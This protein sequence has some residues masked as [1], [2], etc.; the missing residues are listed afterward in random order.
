MR[1]CRGTWAGLTVGWCWC[2]CWSHVAQARHT[3]LEDTALGMAYLHNRR[4]TPLLHRDLKSPNLLLDAQLR[5]KVRDE[6]ARRVG[7]GGTALCARGVHAWLVGETLGGSRPANR[8]ACCACALTQV[9]DFGLARFDG[10]MTGAGHTTTTAVVGTAQWTAPEVF[11]GQEHTT[12]SDVYSFGIVVW[13]M[14]SLQT[15][16]DGQ[17]M[18]HVVRTWRTARGR[19]LA[20]RA[21]KILVVSVCLCLCLFVAAQGMQ[22]ALKHTRPPLPHEAA[23]QRAPRQQLAAVSVTAGDD[24]ASG[25]ADR[26]RGDDTMWP[27]HLVA[28]MK[29]CWAPDPEA[30]PSFNRVCD[31]LADFGANT[32]AVLAG[33]HA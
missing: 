17:S 28:L 5:V 11:L 1:L 2:W 30:R 22:V 13:E 12:A 23:P 8:R 9:C 7:A 6:P 27:P 26:T 20:R 32:D 14:C 31:A 21:H 24:A 3:I 33:H 4:P 10:G 29:A 15:P 25:E 16:F 18:V 19:G